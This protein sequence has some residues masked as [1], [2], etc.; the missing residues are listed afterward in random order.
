MVVVVLFIVVVPMPMS[1]PRLGLLFLPRGQG[2]HLQ[3]LHT[4]RDHAEDPLMSLY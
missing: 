3:A 4:E 1:R 2:L